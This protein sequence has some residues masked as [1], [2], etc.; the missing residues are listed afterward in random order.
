MEE[1]IHKY[2]GLVASL[3]GIFTCIT[4]FSNLS[5]ISKFIQTLLYKPKSYIAVDKSGWFFSP[6]P[7]LPIT[8]YRTIPATRMNYQNGFIIFISDIGHSFVFFNNGDWR[9][10]HGNIDEVYPIV[11]SRIGSPVGNKTDWVPCVGHTTQSDLTTSYMS[12]DG[13][14][15]LSWTIQGYNPTVWRYVANV[16]KISC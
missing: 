3:I 10:Y 1:K 15:I 14:K 5:D 9:N 13:T 7:T 11:S 12:I 16:T 4:G 2:V 8:N 6:Y